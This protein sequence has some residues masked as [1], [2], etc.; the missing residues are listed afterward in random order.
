MSE[1]ELFE[2]LSKNL[3]A[4]IEAE[5]E[6]KRRLPVPF[7]VG[8]HTTLREA[9]ETMGVTALRR[10]QH[11][12]AY[13][14]DAQGRLELAALALACQRSKRNLVEV[15]EVL[16]Q[17]LPGWIQERPADDAGTIPQL[18]IDPATGLRARNAW[19]PL[20]PKAGEKTPQTPR[21]DYASQEVIK[22]WSPRLA[23]WC[24]DCAQFGGPTMAMLDA[25]QA[26]K[27]EA[28]AL[29]KIE[30][31]D[32]EWQQNKLRPDSGATLTEQNLFARGIADP[33]VLAVHRRE[34]KAG[35]PRAKFDNLTVRM[36]IAKRSPEIREIHRQAGEIIEGW[37]AEAKEKAA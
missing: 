8:P 20:P 36:A 25:L 31:G 24:E 16:S 17:V 13:A 27:L 18:P 14:L 4:Q 22:A 7:R 28:E 33:W 6:R 15:I 2:S 3:Q 19:E 34:A 11:N 23:K 29:R 32:R 35:S 10:L 12:R 9:A 26:E 21:F 5:E 37:Q 1:Q 30:Y